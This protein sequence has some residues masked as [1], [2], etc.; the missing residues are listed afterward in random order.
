MGQGKRTPISSTPS[1]WA[2]GWH[3]YLKKEGLGFGAG[4]IDGLLLGAPRMGPPPRN[5]VLG[6]SLG[7][8]PAD[9]SKAWARAQNMAKFRS[10]LF[11]SSPWADD[12]GRGLGRGLCHELKGMWEQGSALLDGSLIGQ[13][14]S[15]ARAAFDAVE[16]RRAFAF[17]LGQ[18]IGGDMVADLFTAADGADFS[19][20]V[21]EVGELLGPFVLDIIGAVVS[22]GAGPLLKRGAT[23]LGLGGDLTQ[24]LARHVRHGFA[25]LVATAESAVPVGPQF[26]YP[27]AIPGPRDPGSFERLKRLNPKPPTGR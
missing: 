20:F 13:L 26:A 11:L 9:G 14:S 23:A 21:Y 5:L 6:R 10:G 18:Q 24:A 2:L 15:A 25:D 16:Q 27:D 1:A 22:G 17:A 8:K 3:Q 12:F 7:L 19:A 4:F